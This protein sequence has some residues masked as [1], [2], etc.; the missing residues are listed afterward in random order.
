MP[1]MQGAQF[2]INDGANGK[3]FLEGEESEETVLKSR[4]SHHGGI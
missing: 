2:A 1:T 4:F 3:L